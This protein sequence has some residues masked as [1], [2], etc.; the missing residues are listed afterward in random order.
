VSLVTSQDARC[1]H[2]GLPDYRRVTGVAVKAA[3][4]RGLAAYPQGRTTLSREDWALGRAQHFVKVATGEVASKSRAGHDTDLLHSMHP[5]RV[6]ETVT[7]NA[8]DLD[9]QVKAL[10][11]ATS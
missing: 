8:A 9:A 5:M 7:V 2:L 3:Y 6:G 11:D 4:D 10:L 1:E